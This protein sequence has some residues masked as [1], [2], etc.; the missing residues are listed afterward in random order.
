MKKTVL[1]IALLMSL[2]VQAEEVKSQAAA[3]VMCEVLICNKIERFSLSLWS[4]IKDDLGEACFTVI[5]PQ[6][7]AVEGK[8]LDEESRW[9]QGKFNPTKKSVTRIKKINMCL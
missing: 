7:E 1:G 5:L 4:H 3:P 9:Y 2:S 6:S 8:V